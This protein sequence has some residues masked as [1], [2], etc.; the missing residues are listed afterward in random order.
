MYY[1]ANLLYK[2]TTW[3]ENGT[4]ILPTA[5]NV[6]KTKVYKDKWGRVVLTRKFLGA[7][8]VDTYNIYDEY[9]NLAMV[10]PPSGVDA[11]GN[12]IASLVFTYA[13]DS[14][15]RLSEKKVPNADVQKFY[16]D[17][18][19]LLTLIQDGNM[20]ASSASKY[21]GTEY[22]EIGQVRKTGWVTTTTPAATALSV[23]IADADKLT[24][25]Q[26][27]PNRTWVKHQGA[28]VLKPAG[29]TTLRDFMWSYIERR[30][31]LEYTGNPVWT[32]KQHLLSKTY[33][34]GTTLVNADLP[35]TD[36]DYG[37]VN[38]MVSSYDGAQKP[39][40]TYNYLYSNTGTGNA[41]NVR[42]A[43]SFEYDNGQRLKQSKYAY[44]FASTAVATPTFILSNM[45]YNW[46]DQVIEK[47][48]AF[49]NNKYLQSQDY[50]Y[51]NRGWLTSINSGFL[52]STLDYPV[53]NCVTTPTAVATN[54][55]S[56][57]TS[58][59]LTPP[60]NSSESNP[61][62]FKEIIRYDAPNTLYPNSGPAQRNG[63][64]SQIEWQ[65]AG[66]EAQGYSFKYDDLDRMTEANYTDIH[67]INKGWV[68]TYDTDNK[69]KE[70]VTYDVRGNIQSM[71]RT[72]ANLYGNIPVNGTNL[73]CAQFNTIDNLTYTYDPNDKN[74]LIKVAESGI[75]YS[76]F[77]TV[78]AAVNAGATHYTYDAN[79]NLT[80]DDNKGITN[81]AYNHLNLPLVI[82]FTVDNASN[83]RRIE[84]IYD[85]SGAKLRKTVFL[86]NI[87]IE[88][89][90]YINGIEYK[91][92]VVDRF[93]NTEGAVIRNSGNT[94]EHEYTI[95][96]HL[97]NARVTYSDA[98]NDGTITVADIKQIN[99]YYPFGMNMVGNWNTAG[100]L[101][102]NKYQYN[103]KEL[104]GGLGW[105][106]YGFRMYDAAIG[107]FPTIDPLGEIYN[108]QS[109]YAYAA[110][111]PVNNIDFMGLGPVG[112]DGMTNEQ[113]MNATNPANNR[114]EATN[115]AYRGLATGQE[116]YE[117]AKA[118]SELKAAT[119]RNREITSA[120]IL[121]TF[122]INPYGHYLLNTKTGE[123]TDNV[124]EGYNFIQQNP[125]PIYRY[126][127]QDY[128]SKSD[129][130]VAILVDKAAEQF[131]IKDIVGL[132]AIIA[133][134]PIL[135]KRFITP[136][137]SPGSS[138]ASTYLS[139]IPGKSPVR[140]PTIIANSSGFRI[141]F[142]KSIGRFLG[143]A[144]P[145]VGWAVLAWDV[146][147]TL[148]NTQVEY[149]KIVGSN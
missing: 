136:G 57:G 32:G 144:V 90:D 76:G 113:W 102:A 107:R 135:D 43:Q 35:I 63:N 78:S 53:F 132:G 54:Y 127:G 14:R 51:N 25:T 118:A 29:A 49:V 18:R 87:A 47:N 46:K 68:N 137:S 149:N 10:I 128:T 74:K 142:T 66:R 99:H 108:F 116:N 37:G 133:G 22:N 126:N 15:I 119:G 67:T 4:Y 72:G 88:V 19:D 111:N 23:T 33:V 94:Y 98:N 70:I 86:N 77:R 55:A 75:L 38:W 26:Y 85:A 100:G 28:K 40:I 52:P 11:N 124:I 80:K 24:E 65:V 17:N 115:S 56:L 145:I 121:G 34:L 5:T 84:F 79:G 81:I 93:A 2:V 27:Y 120:D 61:D 134:Q 21:L 97:G 39:T 95:K 96:D 146:S 103:G 42:Q 30:P 7:Q 1:A 112:A 41:Q 141:A 58:G 147:A 140:L 44:A 31:T 139:K 89:R 114:S 110:N 129:L 3:D 106:D 73:M 117:K 130:Y 104:V 83:P 71:V 82:T 13:Y 8:R 45:N 123:R 92:G 36:N 125:D 143:R 69:Y 12:P 6:G 9:S 62:L 91:G 20:R 59:I 131:G 105:N 64:I 60:A 48:T 148:Y 109:P 101:G 16:Y 50:T 122:T 138:I